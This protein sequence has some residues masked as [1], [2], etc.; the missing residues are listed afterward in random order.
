[1]HPNLK[2]KNPVELDYGMDGGQ[3][4]IEIRAALVGYLLRHWNID[5]T[6]SAAGK[7]GEYHLWLKNHEIL[8]V[9]SNSQLAPGAKP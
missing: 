8:K 4:L 5:C 2:H 7:A 9:V 6:P 1:L 3:R